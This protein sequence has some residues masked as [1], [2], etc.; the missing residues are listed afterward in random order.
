MWKDLIADSASEQVEIDVCAWF[1]RATLDMLVFSSPPRK[2]LT[3][4]I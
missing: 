2:L 4:P 1:G 3:D